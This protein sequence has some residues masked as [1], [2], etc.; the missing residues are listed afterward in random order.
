MRFEKVQTLKE[1]S[2]LIGAE[3]IG[4]ENFPISG[5]NEIHMVEL[6]DITFVDHPKYYQK[7]L[8][9]KASVIIINQRVEAPEGKVLLISNDP[10]ADYNKITQHFKPFTS[11]SHSV[12]PLAKIGKGTIIQPLCFIGSGVQIGQNCIIHSHVSIY[13]GC[14]IGDNVTIHSHSV[15]GADA[16]Y[17]QKKNGIYRKMHS[18]GNVIIGNNVEIGALCSIDKGVSSDTIVGDGTKLDNHVQIGHDTKIGKNCLLGSQVAIAGVT[19]IED[20]VLIWA[21]VGIN[22]DLVIGQGATILATS[23]VDKT[24]E[25]G[26]T[27]YGSPAVEARAKWKQIGKLNRFIDSL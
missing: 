8:N 6:G 22:K 16:Y 9:S 12:S 25:G 18:C 26:K 1:I 10:F 4:N 2:Q 24:L 27:Y 20:D 7:A 13:D 3:Y 15:I 17:F 14:I 23:N 21:K 11:S 5:I 19:T